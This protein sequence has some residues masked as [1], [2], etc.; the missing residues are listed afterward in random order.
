[1]SIIDHPEPGLAEIE[2]AISANRAEVVFLDYLERFKL[3]RE[4]KDDNLR[5]RIKEFMRRIKTLAR[6]CNCVIHIA[7]QLNRKSYDS[8][9]SAPTMAEIS[10]SSAVEKESDRV[11][12]M[13][14]PKNDNQDPHRG[15]F[16]ELI[17]AKNRHGIKGFRVHMFMDPRS[18]KITEVC[19]DANA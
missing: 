2:T 3:P 15:K 13:W 17:Q 5:L 4:S 14:A 12:L 8:V 11:V 16:L 9:E 1:M 18:L 10:E 7:S 6:R 19:R